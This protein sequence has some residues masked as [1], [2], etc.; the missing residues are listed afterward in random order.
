M[1]TNELTPPEPEEYRYQS[2]NLVTYLDARYRQLHEVVEIW[3]SYAPVSNEYN[4]VID[5]LTAELDHL[6][7]ILNYETSQQMSARLEL[8]DAILDEEQSIPVTLTDDIFA[9]LNA[10]ATPDDIEYLLRT[11]YEPDDDAPLDNPPI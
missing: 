10:A 8:Q 7:H 4:H 5:E 2:Q 6:A 11:L 1:E 9:N 3:L